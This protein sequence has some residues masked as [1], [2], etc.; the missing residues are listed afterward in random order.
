MCN[1]NCVINSMLN[2]LQWLLYSARALLKTLSLSLSLSL[3]PPSTPPA[4]SR[5]V[6]QHTI[7]RYSGQFVTPLQSAPGVSPRP[8]PVQDV[9]AAHPASD[10]RPPSWC[11]PPVW[12]LHSA[13][14]LPH[15]RASQLHDRTQVPPAAP[16]EGRPTLKSPVRCER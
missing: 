2:A 1:Q 15:R 12:N 9:Q 16:H 3:S 4:H 7:G 6:T 13:C 11:K 8:R 14:R 10:P 5:T